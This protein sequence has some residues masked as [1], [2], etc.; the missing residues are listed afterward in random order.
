MFN[1][2]RIV[3]SIL[4]LTMYSAAFGHGE[5]RLE[6]DSVRTIVFPDTEERVTVT[7]DLHT[8]SVFSDGH[9]WPSVRVAEAEK[10]GIDALAITEHLEWQPHIADIPHEDRNRAYEEAVRSSK[11]LDLTVIAGAEITRTDEVGHINAVFIRDANALVQRPKELAYDP[12]HLVAT[13]ADAAALAAELS[14]DA[15]D[16]SHS[17]TIDGKQAW[18]PFANK[19]TYFTLITYRYAAA[20]APEEVLA[21]ANK[22]GAFA[23]WNHP[24]FK[25]ARP[26]LSVFHR[27]AIEDGM[28]HG[29]E[30]VNGD[31]Y[32]E[33][34]FTLALK[35][36]LALIGTSDVHGLIAWDYIQKGGHRPVTLVFAESND[37]ES[38]RAA[39]FERRT[40]VWWKDSLI[41]RPRDLDPLLKAMITVKDAEYGGES[42][43]LTLKLH[44]N[45]SADLMLKS[46]SDVQIVRH[47]PLVKLA[48]NQTT[49]LDVIL[50]K[51][52]QKFDLNFEVIN[53]L[54]A[55]GKNANLVLA[56]KV[57]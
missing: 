32:Y 33:H 31:R 3:A 48:A 10:D 23:F 29:V 12:E 14:S 38:I 40:V 16:K 36:N 15:F 50:D 6:S 46:T 2:I 4:L 53:A 56:V 9:V 51:R 24:D 5:V 19:E 52:V 18:A 22:Q 25:S 17:V 37:P 49:S 21:A 39:L 41:G 8:H 30:I 11:S 45:S 28:L 34:A 42:S 57:D 43:R 35:H 54:I 1:L 7:T 13:E 55:P 44:N 47:G 27:A 20:Q 26:E